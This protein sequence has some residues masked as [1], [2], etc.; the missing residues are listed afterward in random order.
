MA[1]NIVVN[2]GLLYQKLQWSDLN[3]IILANRC[4]ILTLL[5]ERLSLNDFSLFFI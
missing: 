4:S 5:L 3:R 1:L 2:L